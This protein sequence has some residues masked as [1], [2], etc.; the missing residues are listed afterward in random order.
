MA[1]QLRPPYQFI[2]VIT[3]QEC[4]YPIWVI[5]DQCINPSKKNLWLTLH[6][7]EHLNNLFTLHLL[8]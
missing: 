5:P 4:I 6:L 3:H 7:Q 8:A 2:L 1:I